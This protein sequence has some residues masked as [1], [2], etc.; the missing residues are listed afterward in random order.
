MPDIPAACQDLS[1][2]VAALTKEY[3]GLAAQVAN[4]EGAPAWQGLVRLGEIRAQLLAAQQALATCVRI[5]T[6]AL[7][8]IL[9]TID[10]TGGAAPGTQTVTLWDISG[11]TPL[12]SAATPVV[13]GTFGF[14]GPVPAQAALTVQTTG[15]AGCDYRSGQLPSPVPAPQVRCEMV[16]CPAITVTPAQLQSWASSFQ[17]APQQVSSSS[18]LISATVAFNTVT[19]TLAVGVITVN[20]VG[21]V[22]GT[23]IGQSFGQLPF[24][25]TVPFSL[26][27]S[28]S[29]KADDIVSFAFAGA[30]PALTFSGGAEASVLNSL[31]SL[32]KPVVSA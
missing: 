32:A 11:S 16:L 13:N 7:S 23:V 31:T 28:V 6:A 14:A 19:V 18:S 10:A 9:V 24:S 22:S 15:S 5:N 1:N 4:E 27:P 3:D 8:G 26:T 21:I 25:A 2:E 17:A 30:G 20:A 12:A 29:P